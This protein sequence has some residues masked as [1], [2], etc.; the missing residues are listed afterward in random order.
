M[1]RVVG[2]L[3]GGI[4][5]ASLG[6]ARS[7]AGIGRVGGARRMAWR[8]VAK[9]RLPRSHSFAAENPFS[10][11]SAGGRWLSTEAAGTAAKAAKKAVEAGASKAAAGAAGAAA[12]AGKKSVGKS[13][14]AAGWEIMK[15]MMRFVWPK[16]SPA[17]KIRVGIAL[18]LL[19]GAKILNIQVPFIFKEII[20]TL[21]VPEHLETMVVVPMG[22]LVAYGLARGGASLFNELRNA[23]FATVAQR[24]IRKVAKDTFLHLH[25]MDLSYH[26]SRETGGLARTIDRGSRGITWVLNSMVFHIVPTAL[27]IAMVCGI[28]WAK[29][30]SEFALVTG[31]TIGAYA[32]FTLAVTQ[33]RT[34]FRKTMNAVDNEAGSK[35][36]DSL[37]NFETVKYFN[38]E[39]F[40]AD[41]YD[42]CLKVYQ[43]AALKTQSSLSMLNW[44]QA[45]IFTTSLTAMMYMT[46]NGVAQGTMTVGDLVMVN[47]LLFQLSIPLN[48]LG[49]VYRELRQALTDMENMFELHN[50]HAAIQ[51]KPD[52]LPLS[53]SGGS[54]KFNNVSFAYDS[55][56]PILDKMSFEI[57]AGSKVAFVGPSGCGKSTILRLLYRFYDPMDGSIEIDGQPITDV[58][59]DS[60]R[61]AIGVVPQDTVLFND[62]IYHN[63]SYGNVEAPEEDVL[64]ASK[65]AQVHDIVQRMPAKYKTKVGERGLKLS[66]GEKQRVSIARAILKNPPILL[67]DEATSALDSNTERTIVDALDKISKD[68]TTVVI[69]HRLST[70]VNS[71]KIVVLNEGR[72]AESGTHDDLLKNKGLYASMWEQQQQQ[73]QI[74]QQ[75]TVDE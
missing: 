47:G 8:E 52:A 43:D 2:R 63:I 3:Q 51:D 69:A 55:D 33:W 75:Q 24:A 35:V 1:L 10:A 42:Q 56:R 27:E 49:S 7:L 17:L 36:V 39:K 60:L 21:N 31:G 50:L 59:M 37:I 5:R 29:C 73:Q 25:N 4:G 44:G 64:N 9:D 32:I 40:E 15:K 34:K 54:I 38:N 62:T 16:E 28:L 13:D 74:Q 58:K 18:G 20:D 48:F 70:V 67:C 65:M 68:R 46:A 66:G 14:Y 71:D 12:G 57:P 61:K 30:G 23:V 72:I 53:L 6:G 26:L 41:R 11:I 45:A 22:L 19:V